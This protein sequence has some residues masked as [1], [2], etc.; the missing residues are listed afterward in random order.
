MLGVL[1]LFL[2][3]LLGAPAPA[4]TL[5]HA[6]RPTIAPADTLVR[7][8]PCPDADRA[9]VGTILFLGNAVTKERILRVELDFHEG[10]TL[11]VADIAARL[12]AN[13][14][15]LF[16][17]QLFHAVVVQASCSGGK[18]L[19]VFGLQERWYLFPV[20]ILS[21][22]DRNL[23]SWL[24]RADRWKRVDYGVHLVRSNFRGRNE[25]IMAN[26]QLGFN[27]KYELFYEAPGL[28]HNRRL[29]FGA[30][31]SYYQS[32]A[33]DYITRGDRLVPF[34]A[35]DNFPIQRLYFT[36][37]LRFRHTVQFLTALDVSYHRER[38]SD[39]I[40]H[41][42][43]TYYLGRT[44]RE[45]LDV[46][47]TTT[48]NQRNTFAYPLTGRYAQLSVSHRVFLGRTAPSVTTV[49]ATYSR[50][51]ALGHRFYYSVGLSGQAR[52]AEKLAYAD[53]RALGYTDLVR[54]YD[55]YVIDGRHYGLLQQGLSYQLLQPRNIQLGSI[56][57]PKINSI[58]LA[59]YLN[60][61]TDAGYVAAPSPLPQN[62]LPNRLL[63]AVGLGLHLVTYYDRVFTAE[64]TLNGLGQT[65]YFFRAEFPI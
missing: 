33:L 57:N 26:L 2:Q 43:P 39:S 27:R 11:A 52:F 13:R 58:P 40:Q 46:A 64:Y 10:D 53:V 14:S 48:R 31:A 8:M 60:I 30:G 54:G 24:D 1:L 6:L 18:W 36:G 59:L 56:D 44:Q 35:D 50:Y 21:L 49:H 34:R 7:V 65:G 55:E 45:Y 41:R 19:I 3:T 63:S 37:G 9:A 28:G 42:N 38:I 51:L 17:L 20:P 25:Q 12:E 16:N 5:P 47:F 4:D 29:G 15:R 32:H 62:G 61:F 22:A 23:R